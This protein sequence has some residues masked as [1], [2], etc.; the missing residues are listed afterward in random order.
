MDGEFIVQCV[1]LTEQGYD[2]IREKLEQDE[3][4]GGDDKTAG[5][6]KTVG[7]AHTGILSRPVIE[8]DNGL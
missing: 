8:T 3:P 5:D 4:D 7:L 2:L 6:G 1:S